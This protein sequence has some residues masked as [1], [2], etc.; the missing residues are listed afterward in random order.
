[1]HVIR[2]FIITAFVFALGACAATQATTPRSRVAEQ[3]GCT[4]EDTSV[5]EIGPVPGQPSARW[6]VTG[7]GRTAV[8]I[9][10][11]PEVRDCWR[12]GEIGPDPQAK[13]PAPSPSVP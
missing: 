10:T 9:C 7:C 8:Y 2:T 13:A 5:R 1:M 4:T 6:Q 3:M 11:A 12:E